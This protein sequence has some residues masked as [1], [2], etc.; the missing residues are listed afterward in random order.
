LTDAR[1]FSTTLKIYGLP[2]IIGCCATITGLWLSSGVTWSDADDFS[3]NEYN[4]LNSMINI[5]KSSNYTDYTDFMAGGDHRR[6][7]EYPFTGF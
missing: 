1:G 4:S 3:N 5:I 6:F 2:R 7:F